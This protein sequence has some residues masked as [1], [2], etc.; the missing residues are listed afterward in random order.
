ME[1]SN[2]ERRLKFSLV[3]KKLHVVEEPT[4]VS[5]CTNSLEALQTLEK[6]FKVQFNLY[7]SLMYVSGNGTIF[8]EHVI[9]S[10]SQLQNHLQGG[11]N[12]VSSKK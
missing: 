4:R 1:N 2:I 9:R 5:C 11:F 6:S 12:E 8:C 3:V 7:L 10:P